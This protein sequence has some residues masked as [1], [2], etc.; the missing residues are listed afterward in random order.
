VEIL[1]GWPTTIVARPA[2]IDLAQLACERD[3]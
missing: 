2:L 3:G 1:G